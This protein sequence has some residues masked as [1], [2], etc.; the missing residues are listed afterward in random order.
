[1]TDHIL[2]KAKEFL[3]TANGPFDSAALS[4]AVGLSRFHLHRLFKA[5]FG[6]TPQRYH[7]ASKSSKDDS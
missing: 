7:A 2:E 1:M 3:D 4:K 5:R 6:L